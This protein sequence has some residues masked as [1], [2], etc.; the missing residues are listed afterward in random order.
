MTTHNSDRPCWTNAAGPSR[1]SPLPIETPRAMTPGPTADTH[2][3][4]RGLG[5]SGSSADCQASRPDR[6]SRGVT[7]GGAKAGDY[8]SPRP[9]HTS[10]RGF[11][12][13][14]EAHEPGRA[15]VKKIVTV[16]GGAVLSAMAL[17][18]GQGAQAPNEA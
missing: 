16:T 14:P 8:N 11:A 5:G 1:N 18:A 12:S 9:P 17:L 15:S 2:S 13:T 7:E 6:A 10:E 4:P 3:S